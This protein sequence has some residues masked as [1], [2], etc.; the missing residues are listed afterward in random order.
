MHER[1]PAPA[2]V[3][4]HRAAAHVDA[5]QCPRWAP[6]FDSRGLVDLRR[7]QL[8]SAIA[9]YNEA[10]KINPKIPYRP[11]HR[12]GLYE[13]TSRRRAGYRINEQ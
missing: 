6:L 9:D 13:L 11:N 8:D 10:L 4:R 5:G 2:V 12:R 1:R 7:K 3:T